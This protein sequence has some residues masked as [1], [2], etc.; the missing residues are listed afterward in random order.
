MAK[1][2]K[3]SDVTKVPE[4]ATRFERPPNILGD[5][6]YVYT[7]FIDGIDHK[8]RFA[9]NKLVMHATFVNRE[10][11]GCDYR[12]K[13][14]EERLREGRTAILQADAKAI[15][16]KRLKKMKSAARKASRHGG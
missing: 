14:H 1:Y 9:N 6:Q 10:W 12:R 11:H 3:L 4:D 16:E 13:A 2:L 8:W 7:A 5:P 15:E